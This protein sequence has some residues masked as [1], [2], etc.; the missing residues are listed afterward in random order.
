MFLVNKFSPIFLSDRTSYELP[1]N[2][3]VAFR[4]TLAPFLN[5]DG[6]NYLDIVNKGYFT[7]DNHNLKVFF[8]VYPI[9]IK[10]FSLNGLINPVYTGIFIS[11]ASAFCVLVLFYKMFGFKAALLLFVFP[12]SF[13]F[14][15]FYTESLFLLLILLFFHF[16]NKK[17][18]LIASIF[19]AVAS[20]TR[21]M[22]LALLPVLLFEILKNKGTFKKYLWTVFVTPLGFVLYFLYAGNSIVS[23]Q[24][25]WNREVGVFGP[26]KA[27][28]DS[29][30]HII[31]GP[32]NSYD[33][34]FVYPVI[35]LEFL[36][37]IFAVFIVIKMYRMIET[38]YFI[39]SLISLLIILLGG[40]LA[41]SPRYLLVIFP[42]FV[43]LAKVLNKFYY[44]YLIISILMLIFFSA[45]FLRGYW[46]A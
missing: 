13:F 20:G 27:L 2:N 19:A 15:A 5:F 38:K 28:S 8:P 17:K 10:V 32:L 24:S 6:R 35:V 29:M 31:Q 33:N 36:I 23:S 9:I 21:V 1:G 18:Y 12:T 40:S 7:K 25:N 39:Y 43:Y 16:L 44:A 45:L 46:V 3:M 26:F 42:I 30:I 41:S 11:L 4:F 37:F 14:A 22:G 34:I